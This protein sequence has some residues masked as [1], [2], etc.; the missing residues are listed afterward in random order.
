MGGANKQENARSPLWSDGCSQIKLL[1]T[2]LSKRIWL[3]AVA[4][5]DLSALLDLITMWLLIDALKGES[6]ESKHTVSRFFQESV[7]HSP[8]KHRIKSSVGK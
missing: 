2:V 1:V 6:S 4:C 5:S 3:L 8:I 7:G